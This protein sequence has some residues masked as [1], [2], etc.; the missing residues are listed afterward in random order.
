VQALD[1][2]VRVT[3]W[4]LL[5]EAGGAVEVTPAPVD[6]ASSVGPFVLDRVRRY[7]VVGIHNS[8]GPAE[9]AGP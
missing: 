8:A 5:D 1:G 6:G 3:L 4:A 7:A 2:S 9:T